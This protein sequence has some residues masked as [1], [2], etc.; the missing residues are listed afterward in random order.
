[1][2]RR[3]TKALEK[4]SEIDKKIQEYMKQKEELLQKAQAEI[5]S[6]ILEKW[7]VE[8]DLE[9]VYEA[10]DLLTKDA[11]KIIEGE[12]KKENSVD[13]KEHSNDVMEPSSKKEFEKI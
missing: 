2:A 6:Y 1:M 5:G 11:L 4:A 13:K 8:G 10:I 9:K 7:N 3:N 12:Y